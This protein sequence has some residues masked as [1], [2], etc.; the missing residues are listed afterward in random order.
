MPS[1]SCASPPD[2]LDIIFSRSQAARAYLSKTSRRGLRL[3][4][5]YAHQVAMGVGTTYF[6]TS[7]LRTN[8]AVTGALLRFGRGVLASRGLWGMPTANNPSS[9][10]C[11]Y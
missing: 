7:V 8:S 4:N 9:C 2:A 11:R 3:V 10:T 1:R 5:F 6:P